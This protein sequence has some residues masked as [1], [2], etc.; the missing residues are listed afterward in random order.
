MFFISVDSSECKELNK[1][2]LK[3][4]GR[5]W[6]EICE[7]TFQR[8]LKQKRYFLLTQKCLSNTKYI[9]RIAVKFSTTLWVLYSFC[10]QKKVACG[11]MFYKI[12][13]FNYQIE[14][15]WALAY[16]EYIAMSYGMYW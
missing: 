7:E 16:W 1:N 3:S 5:L 15:H 6:I 11:D 12:F 2:G 4:Y 14:L 9:F 8:P 13:I 10:A